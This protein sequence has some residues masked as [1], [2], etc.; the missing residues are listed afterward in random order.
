MR[1]EEGSSHLRKVWPDFQSL[2]FTLRARGTFRRVLSMGV[3]W[4]QFTF[5]K[6]SQ[7]HSK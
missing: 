6:S 3:D 2:G 5:R 7:Q 1:V 4:F